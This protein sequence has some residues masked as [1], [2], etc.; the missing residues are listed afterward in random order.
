MSFDVLFQIMKQMN[1]R[2]TTTGYAGEWCFCSSSPY[3]N[4]QN[5]FITFGRN[6]QSP[7]RKSVYLGGRIIL[8]ANCEK[9]HKNYVDGLNQQHTC[10]RTEFCLWLSISRTGSIHIKLKCMNL[11]SAKEQISQFFCKEGP[12]Q[13]Y[14]GHADLVSKFEDFVIRGEEWY[15]Q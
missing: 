5:I 11:Q 1:S 7:W 2:Y 9:I 12:V 3:R 13:A 4:R 15:V 8:S 6:F 10:L 14:L